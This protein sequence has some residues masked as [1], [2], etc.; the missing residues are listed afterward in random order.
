MPPGGTSAVTVLV[1]IKFR[2]YMSGK[3]ELYLLYVSKQYIISPVL[4]Q[5]QK[6]HQ[7]A[8]ALMTVDMHGF[9]L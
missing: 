9:K 2:V 7:M 5:F 4:T 8:Q 6:F 1:Y 3:K